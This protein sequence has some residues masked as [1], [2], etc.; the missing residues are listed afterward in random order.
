MASDL[1]KLV[2]SDEASVRANL[3]RS[4]R[5]AGLMVVVLC[6]FVGLFFAVIALIR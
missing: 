4:L 5:T 2:S 6:G 3:F 1:Y